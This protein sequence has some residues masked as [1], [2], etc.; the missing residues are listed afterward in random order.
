MTK[1]F[2][3]RT[4]AIVLLLIASSIVMMLAKAP[5]GAAVDIQPSANPGT[6]DNFVKATNDYTDSARLFFA[7]DMVFA[8]SY[9]LLFAAIFTVVRPYQPFF[10]YFG[11]AFAIAAGLCDLIENS[12][13]LSYAV[14]AANGVPLENPAIVLLSVLTT[15]K[16]VGA[17]GVFIAYC[18]AFPLTTWAGRLS[19]ITMATV[20]LV[21]LAGYAFS[22]WMSYKNSIFILPL[23]F[24][25][26]YLWK[27]TGAN[28]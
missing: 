28:N 27:Q 9:T 15:L 10:A 20:P 7:A 1:A 8:M 16:W 26:Y 13:Y 12:L 5:M 22:D 24:V 6:I 23:P 25:L 14:R 21:I 2:F 17:S 19:V 4:M 3:W 18:F 11:L